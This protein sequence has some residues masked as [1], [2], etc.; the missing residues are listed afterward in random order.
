MLKELSDFL[1]PLPRH[2]RRLWR[3]DIGT[4]VNFVKDD[5]RVRI[6]KGGAT[7]S[8]YYHD[9]PYHPALTPANVKGI[10]VNGWCWA[11]QLSEY[12]TFDLD[13]IANHGDGLADE[14]LAEVVGRLMDVPEAEIVRSKSGRGIHVRIFF[15]PQ[16]RAISHTEHARN[17][18]RALAWLVQKTALPLEAAV[19][20]CAKIAWIWHQDTAPSGFELLKEAT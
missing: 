1:R 7:G 17:G 3:P 19:D 15:D 2:L 5:K 10:G 12:V 14:Q 6:P 20:A 16:P 11:D 18:A 9:H 4:Q 13:S 8:P